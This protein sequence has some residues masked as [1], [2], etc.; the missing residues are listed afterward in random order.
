MNNKKKGMIT[1]AMKVMITAGILVL[2]VVVFWTITN[3]ITTHTGYAIGESELDSFAQCLT[4]SGVKFYGSDSCP[5]CKDQKNMFRES[6]I[7]IDYKECSDSVN[8][9]VCSGLRGVP[10]WEIPGVEGFVYGTQNLN[11]LA[12]LSGCEL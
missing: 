7:H 9:A 8:S 10:A 1:A 3:S 12:E 2:L 11:Q 4:D 6:F 5:H